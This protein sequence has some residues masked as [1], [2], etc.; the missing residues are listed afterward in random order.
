M[1]RLNTFLM[2]KIGTFG[3][4]YMRKRMTK[5]RHDWHGEGEQRI[6]SLSLKMLGP[7]NIQWSYWKK[8]QN[9]QKY[10]FNST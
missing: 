9:K 1:I 5:D 7:G 2:R 8:I 3:T 4:F 6:F 10:F